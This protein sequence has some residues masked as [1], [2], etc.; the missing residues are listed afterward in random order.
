MVL[1]FYFLFYFYVIVVL[2]GRMERGGES[3]GGGERRG[4][5]GGGLNVRLNDLFGRCLDRTEYPVCILYPVSAGRGKVI[6][7]IMEV[8]NYYRILGFSDYRIDKLDSSDDS[9]PSA[10]VL[11]FSCQW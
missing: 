11:C 8:C 1:V 3:G 9:Q 6:A 4:G 5:E 7:M 10:V 2:V